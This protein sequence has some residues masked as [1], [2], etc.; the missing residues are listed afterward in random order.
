MGW[1]EVRWE[2]TETNR[3][4]WQWGELPR[5]NAWEQEPWLAASSCVQLDVPLNNLFTLRT[6]EPWLGRSAASELSSSAGGKGEG[7]G[8][9]LPFGVLP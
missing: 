1:R 9:E 3:G 5:G 8:E 6:S 4:N 2:R 7:S